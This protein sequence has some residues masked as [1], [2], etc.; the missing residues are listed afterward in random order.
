MSIKNFNDT[1][2]DRTRDLPASSAVPQ[3]TAPARTSCDSVDWIILTQERDN[4]LAFVM[5]AMNIKCEVPLDQLR[6]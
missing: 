2:G 6:D 3:P 5:P 1:N 4:W